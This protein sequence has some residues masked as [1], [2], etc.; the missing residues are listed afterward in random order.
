MKIVNNNLELN[1]KLAGYKCPEDVPY[2]RLYVYKVK[3]YEVPV[4]RC[5]RVV[6]DPETGEVLMR[7]CTKMGIFYRCENA[8][9]MEELHTL[10]DRVDKYGPG[11][12]LI[13][14]ARKSKNTRK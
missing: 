13:A 3:K 4:T 10:L 11:Y 2:W 6:T 8:Y 7:K 9:T 1:Y 5:C 12:R 14:W